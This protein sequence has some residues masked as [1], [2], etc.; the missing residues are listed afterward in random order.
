MYNPPVHQTSNL[1]NR[2][3][4]VYGNSQ[5]L[6]IPNISEIQLGVVTEGVELKLAQ[7][8][9]ARIIQ[10][11]IQSL[12]NLGIIQ[13]NIQ[14]VD[15]TIYPRYD[16]VDGIQ[17]LKGYQVTHLLSVTIEKLDQT[18]LV[19]DT[20]VLNG[21]NRVSNITFTVKN[22]DMYYQQALKKALKDSV[23]KAQTIANT[24]RLNL[25]PT[26]VKISEQIIERPSTP[27][28]IASSEVVGGISTPIQPGQLKI[29]AKVEVEF[30]FVS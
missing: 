30:Q 10:Q 28:R 25:D 1:N 20:A 24:M 6:M 15:F 13:E 5:I 3:I 4:N 18:G 17:Q 19:I 7:Q 11:I 2:S 21:A 9:N 8:E 14:T 29:E 27:F 26:P 22:K 23:T 12:I 16:F